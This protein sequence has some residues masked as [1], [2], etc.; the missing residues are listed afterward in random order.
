MSSKPF[1]IGII[2]IGVAIGYVGGFLTYYSTLSD[3]EAA[4]AA[5]VRNELDS[6]KEDLAKS[7][8]RVSL[9]ME[10]N[11]NLHMSFTQLTGESEAMQ[12]R[13]DAMKAALNGSSGSL[14]KIEQGVTLIHMVSGPMPFEG[15]ELA[16]WRLAVVNDTAK[17]D[18]ALVPTVLRLVD[19]WV[20]IVRFEENEPAINTEEWHRWN[21]EWQKKALILI[22]AHTI[23]IGRITD[24]LIA[25]IDSMKSLI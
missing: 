5:A 21:V 22:E 10:D 11:E 8:S 25:E 13:I 17:L 6:L 7:N 23:A 2:A 18:P 3:V 24:V 16:E 20:D 12:K 1:V 4:N 9:L 19:A 15:E 14:S